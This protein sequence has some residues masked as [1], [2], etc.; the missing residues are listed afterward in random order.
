MDG[1]G[2]VLADQ[3]VGSLQELRDL[4]SQLELLLGLLQLGNVG[5]QVVERRGDLSFE[6]IEES[7]Y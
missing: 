3:L 5:V 4:F 2:L 1:V 6:A 7:L